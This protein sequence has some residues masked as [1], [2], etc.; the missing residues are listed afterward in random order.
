MYV[1]SAPYFDPIYNGSIKTEICPS[2]G[3]ISIV[4]NLL[5]DMMFVLVKQYTRTTAALQGFRVVL[6]PLLG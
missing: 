2:E 3:V 6:W 5:L 4:R 1:I